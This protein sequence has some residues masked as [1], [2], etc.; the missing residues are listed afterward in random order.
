MAYLPDYNPK[1]RK[2]PA[3][4][5]DF[6]VLQG[7]EMVAVLDTKYRD[8]WNKPLPREMLYQLAVY[9]RGQGFGGAATI[10]YPTTGEGNVQEARIEIRDTLYGHSRAQVILRP[11]NLLYLEQLVSGANAP[12]T[13][14]ELGRYARELAFGSVNA[15]A[16]KP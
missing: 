10:L 4:R 7:Q 12:A 8:L 9:A 16:E 1:K 3:P 5:P 13:S 14:K 2:D 6:V 15:K 11:V